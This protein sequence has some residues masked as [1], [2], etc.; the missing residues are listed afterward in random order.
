MSAKH[1]LKPQ[2]LLASSSRVSVLWLYV[3]LYPC[4]SSTKPSARRLNGRSLVFAPGQIKSHCPFSPDPLHAQLTPEPDYGAK[5]VARCESLPRPAGQVALWPPSGQD[6][7]IDGEDT[8]V[9]DAAVV[10]DLVSLVVSDEDPV[11]RVGVR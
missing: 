5:R 1:H 6:H 7:Q 2:C 8:A 11:L 3:D 9:L 4:S 10:P